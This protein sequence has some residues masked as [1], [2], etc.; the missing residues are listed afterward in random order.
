MGN[1]FALSSAI[2][3][4]GMAVFPATSA[5]IFLLLSQSIKAL[6]ITNKTINPRKCNAGDCSLHNAKLKPHFQHLS[7]ATSH[8]QA[9]FADAA[10]ICT[11]R[12]MQLVTA[13]GGANNMNC[14]VPNLEKMSLEDQN[15]YKYAYIWTSGMAE[16]R[17]C[18]NVAYSWCAGNRN[19]I[20][21]EEFN[22]PL[23]VNRKERCL[24]LSMMTKTLI[25]MDCNRQNY[26]YCEVTWTE[27]VK[28]CCSIGM[29]P[30]RVTDKFLAALNSN[31]DITIFE[32]PVNASEDR[33]LIKTSF[34]TAATRQG[35]AGQYRFCSHDDVGPWDSTDDFW[36][37]V[38]PRDDGSCLVVDRQYAKKGAPFGVRQ[39]QC[40]APTGNFACQ[41]D[42]K[43][44]DDV[45]NSGS[46]KTGQQMNVACDQPNCSKMKFC[47]INGNYAVPFENKDERVLL[48]PNRLGEWRTA[49]GVR[50]L[51]Y[52]E[53]LSWKDSLEF[54]CSLGMRLVSVQ[55]TNVAMAVSDKNQGQFCLKLINTDEK[56][57]TL[58]A[59]NCASN[60][61]QPICETRLP[62]ESYLQEIFNECKLTHRVSE[63]ELEK[64]KSTGSLDRLSYKMKCFAT[65][66]AELLG[67]MYEGGK[68]WE[69][70]VEK[71][72]RRYKGS[73]AIEEDFRSV[74]KKY[75]TS[76]FKKAA[77]NLDALRIIIMENNQQVAWKSTLLVNQALDRFWECNRM[78]QSNQTQGE[79]TF[80]HEFIKCFTSGPPSLAKFWEM[81]LRNLFDWKDKALSLRIPSSY[82]YNDSLKTG[83]SVLF[84]GAPVDPNP[85]SYAVYVNKLSNS[86]EF[87]SSSCNFKHFR[88]EN[89][90]LEDACSQ[91]AAHFQ[92]TPVEGF[93]AN[94][95]TDPKKRVHPAVAA[96]MCARA[97]GT[98]PVVTLLSLAY[99]R[100][101]KEILSKV[102]TNF[103]GSMIN[104]YVVMS[105]ISMSDVDL[106]SY[107]SIV[108]NIGK[109]AVI[110]DNYS[111]KYTSLLLDETF[112]DSRGV[113]RWC[114][115]S[116]KLL[117]FAGQ[118][119]SGATDRFL[120][121]SSQDYK[122]AYVYFNYKESAQY[123]SLMFFSIN[124]LVTPK[125][126]TAGDCS[127]HDSKLR[128]FLSTA[129]KED[130]TSVFES[131]FASSSLEIGEIFYKCGRLFF[132]SNN[133][134]SF[135]D[136]LLV[137]AKRKMQLVAMEE[138]ANNMN[139]L[140]HNFEKMTIEKQKY[141]FM[142]TSG[143][144]EGRGCGN[145]AYSWCS[146]NRSSIRTAEFDLP[147]EVSRE[148]S[149]LVLSMMTKTLIRMNCNDRNYFLCEYKCKKVSCVNREACVRNVTYFDAAGKLDRASL[150]GV[151]AEWQQ[152]SKLGKISVT[153][154]IFGYQKTSWAEGVKLCCSIGM[155]PI[156]VTDTFLAAFNSKHSITFFKNSVNSTDRELIKTSFW[157]A[158][159]RQGCAGQFRFCLH[160]DVGPWDST[161]D[162][163]DMVNPRD[164]GS[165]LVVDRQYAKEGAPFGVRQ[166][167]CSA[168][169]ANFACQ[170]DEVLVNVVESSSAAAQEA[171]RQVF[172][173][174]TRKPLLDVIREDHLGIYVFLG[175]DISAST[176]APII[177]R[178]PLMCE[179]PIC[180]SLNYCQLNE[181][182]KN[183]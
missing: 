4:S 176:P 86:E 122:E 121:Y 157:T 87:V 2:R 66:I 60:L 63:R 116:E 114:S 81:D 34:W 108:Q 42:G 178:D 83:S 138:G 10:L 164:D 134:G 99:V 67:L 100:I 92:Q 169:T 5:F 69:D 32:N 142:W 166:V 158:A 130:F 48:K 51:F 39:V 151:W 128:N 183:L 171:D 174:S 36:D 30:V 25:R 22:L 175:I 3:N 88:P 154:Y 170:M 29:S 71:A 78:V 132:R 72:M 73:Q 33:E 125:A 147:A 91:I 38:N 28:F 141:V 133:Q 97:N 62:A 49:C 101:L 104:P 94:K 145:A 57:P 156:R 109:A 40:S 126:C 65:C 6:E 105:E 152:T 17:S 54:C 148:E 15:S 167:Q 44:V 9:N 110:L 80:I 182:F 7:P 111:L 120:Y 149:C 143:A 76:L 59:V 168:P 107:D 14:L 106:D 43:K 47:E 95:I 19:V 180:L 113:V 37:M 119:T 162:F 16:G 93:Y 103:V 140:A 21:P 1:I 8:N 124:A 84:E 23:E 89:L 146:G 163:W 177:E 98:L 82:Y 135:S 102:T 85:R 112:T 155:K 27:N 144:A 131:S 13:E 137:C 70:D 127:L 64:F 117:Q 58:H 165:C 55:T 26:F 41:T 31:N 50:Y 45:V 18:G 61:F 161:D 56:G 77:D 179:T 79:C 68:F 139:C 115:T 11:K 172:S 123:P 75:P 35:C 46:G 150:N 53:K 24:V 20:R 90:T 129:I 181:S 96:A 118:A 52:K 136:A 159:T 160:D 153:T 12:K 74:V 173:S